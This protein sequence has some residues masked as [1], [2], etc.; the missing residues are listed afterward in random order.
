MTQ[1]FPGLL[2][3]TGDTLM[4]REKRKK[5]EKSYRFL[6]FF[7]EGDIWSKKFSYKEIDVDG[8]VPSSQHVHW[9]LHSLCQLSLFLLFA[10]KLISTGTLCVRPQV[11]LAE[12]C[13]VD[14]ES[15]QSPGITWECWELEVLKAKWKL[16]GGVSVTLWDVSF[17][18][19]SLSLWPCHLGKQMILMRDGSLSP[20]TEHTHTAAIVLHCPCCPLEVTGASHYANTDTRKKKGGGVTRNGSNLGLH[21]RRG[22]KNG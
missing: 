7:L 6:V 21:Y 4:S 18:Q 12:F 11:E 20:G 2:L 22:F 10:D 8:T 17:H 15:R 5:K 13:H 1:G 14:A 16:C 3:D 19:A 9:N